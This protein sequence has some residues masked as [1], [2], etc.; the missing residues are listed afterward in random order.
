MLPL[1]M[2]KK[3]TIIGRP[4]KN[5]RTKTVRI[6]VDIETQVLELRDLY[7][8]NEEGKIKTVHPIPK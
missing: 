3:K 4:K 5:Y 8:R 7:E 2:R 1:N 6:P